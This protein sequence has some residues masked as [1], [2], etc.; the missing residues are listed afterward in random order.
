M[1]VAGC[2]FLLQNFQLRIGTYYYVHRM[3]QRDLL[4]DYSKA[5]RLQEIP[6]YN[7]TMNPQKIPLSMGRYPE[8]TSFGSLEDPV[9]ESLGKPMLIKIGFLDMLA[10]MFPFFFVVMAFSM[11]VPLVWTRIMLSFFFLAAGKGLFGWL[12]V[13]PD[14]NGWQVCHDRLEGPPGHP[15]KY[16]VEWYAQERSTWEILTMDPRSR[17]CADMMWSGHTY[18]VCIFAFGL[19]E[20]VHTAMRYQGKWTRYACEM[21]VVTVAVVQQSVEIYFVLKSRFHYTSDVVMALFVTYLLWSNGSIAIT[22]MWWLHSKHPSHQ[23]ADGNTNKNRW[24]PAMHSVGSISSG[25]CCLPQQEPTHY[26]Y[27]REQLV[28]I[29]AL[30]EKATDPFDAEAQ[31]HAAHLQLTEDTKQIIMEEMVMTNPM[32]NVKYEKGFGKKAEAAQ[33]NV[34]PVPRR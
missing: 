16:P 14:S 20:C 30:A 25:C 8:D 2:G 31:N 24:I 6:S 34:L 21:L 5:N 1:F 27:T 22:A 33:S 9:A 7:G 29:M 32:E 26:I 11:D 23:D 4:I 12:T 28:L 3:V 10:L 15:G 13:E 19:W 17:L 18:F